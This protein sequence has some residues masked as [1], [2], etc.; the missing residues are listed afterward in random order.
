M[1]YYTITD[2]GERKPWALVRVNGALYE[3]WV[4]G[5]GWVDTPYF[6]TYFVGGDVGAKEVSE[7]EA[8]RLQ[9]IGIGIEGVPGAE[10]MRGA[11]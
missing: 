10:A 8:T 2:L 6:L 9:G 3:R 7:A 11:P 4:P 5:K 1:R